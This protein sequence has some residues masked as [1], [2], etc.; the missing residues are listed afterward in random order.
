MTKGK[1]KNGLDAAMTAAQMGP[2]ALARLIG[3]NKQNVS[4]W[5][6]QSRR[7]TPEVAQKIAPH[8]NTTA[9]ALLLL[10]PSKPVKI[11]APLIPRP[12]YPAAEIDKRLKEI[13]ILAWISAGD[14]AR[15]DVADEK[16]GDITFYGLKD[17]DWIA[18][19][20]VGDSMDKI[21][22]PG[23]IILVNRNDKDLRAGACYVI[24]DLDGSA[25]YKRFRRPRTFE[26]VSTNKSLKPLDMKRGMVIVGRVYKTILDL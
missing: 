8:L 4:R 2:T 22:P 16:L 14:L 17:G 15:D 18:L 6:D 12:D 11:D 9:E 24:E 23:S 1:F 25:T 21:S 26:P 10:P 5:R 13:P 20:V 3:D 7:L 19:K